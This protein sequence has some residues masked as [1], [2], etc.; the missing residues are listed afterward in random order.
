MQLVTGI[1]STSQLETRFLLFQ[2]RS[3]K[4]TKTRSL[5]SELTWTC[6]THLS[7]WSQNRLMLITSVFNRIVAG[8]FD[9]EFWN[10]HKKKQNKTLCFQ[11]FLCFIIPIHCWFLVRINACMEEGKDDWVKWRCFDEAEPGQNRVILL[12]QAD[13]RKT[14][15]STLY[16]NHLKRGSLADA[17]LVQV[18]L[19]RFSDPPLFWSE[20]LHSSSQALP[21]L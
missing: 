16:C 7:C 4:Q 2:H 18:C 15:T 13:A 19:S 9:V 11:A 17:W 21:T 6:G 20:L 10:T 3:R 14:T 5:E 12:I 8:W 1:P